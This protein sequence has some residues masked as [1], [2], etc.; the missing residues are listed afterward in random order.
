MNMMVMTP[1]THAMAM[2]LPNRRL[3]YASLKICSSATSVPA[4]PNVM[5]RIMPPDCDAAMNAPTKLMIIK[6]LRAGSVTYQIFWKKL[7]PSISAASYV[8]SGGTP[9]HRDYAGEHCPLG[10]L[11][12]G[13]RGII[14]AEPS[15]NTADD[16]IQYSRGAALVEQLPHEHHH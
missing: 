14:H 3:V 16:L 5:T 15:R 10:V 8:S 6:D 11:K 2:A 7:A 4:R 13:N 9:D 1:S 12:P